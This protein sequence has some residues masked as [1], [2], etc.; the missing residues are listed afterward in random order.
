MVRTL[1]AM[2]AGLLRGALRYVL[3]T[4]E[5]LEVIAEADDLT[6]VLA[7]LRGDRPDVTVLDVEIFGPDGSAAAQAKW[8]E[9]LGYRVLV[10]LDL[11][12]PRHLGGTLA[13]RPPTVGFLDHTAPP[14]RV[15][16]GVRRLARDEPVLDAEVVLAALRPKGP[17]TPSELRVLQTAALGW[18]VKEIAAK[19]ALSP[20]TVRNH[21]SHI[22]AKTGARTRIEAIYIAQ[23]AGWI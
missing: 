8:E 7:V 21:L 6:D 16:D 2:P 5:D 19:L 11:R 9:V 23:E 10:L 15:L 20:G 13:G 1:L 18:P 22:I 3:S 12:R 17:L 14:E 4:Q